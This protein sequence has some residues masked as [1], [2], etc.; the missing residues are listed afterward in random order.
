MQISVIDPTTQTVFFGILFIAVLLFSTRKSSDNLFF[1]ISKTLQLKGL[2]ILAI[3][4]SHIGYFLSRETTFLYP[5]SVDAGV[6]VNLFLFLS[7]FGLTIS[8]IKRP[9]SPLIFY[10]KRLLKLYLPMWIVVTIFVALDLV[11]LKINYPIPKLVNAYAGIFQTGDPFKDLNSPLW[12]FTLILFYYLIFPLTFW[13]RFKYL[14]PLIIYIVGYVL[15]RMPIPINWDVLNL[16]KLH[17]LAFPIGILFALLLNE[18]KINSFLLK[19]QT[20]PGRIFLKYILVIFLVL[21]F[22]YTSIHSGVGQDPKLEQSIS[23]ITMFST[24]FIFTLI[25]FEF[26]F[27]ELF[28]VYSF[29]IYLIHWP[30]LSR[31][32]FLY[33]YLP[34]SAATTLYLG[35]FLILGYILNKLTKKIT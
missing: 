7:G 6:G 24:I 31:Y 14:S 23:L 5:F 30:L 20:L 11:F 17:T 21:V 27:L 2:A 28:G 35:L 1:G 34:A 10:K 8:S 13:K 25:D 26:K 33:K 29:E 16:Y 32:D 15:F 4:F 22:A 9:I 3:I 12:Y 18:K 19:L